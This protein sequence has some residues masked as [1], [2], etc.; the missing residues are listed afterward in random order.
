MKFTM[1]VEEAA[2]VLSKSDRTIRNYIKNGQLSSI[3]KGRTRLLDPEEVHELHTEG[4]LPRISMSEIRTMRAQIRRLEAEMAVVQHVLDLKNES[5]GVTEEYA[6]GLMDAATEQ[7]GR[8]AGSYTIREYESWANIFARMDEN[9]IQRLCVA[10]QNPDAWKLFLRLSARMV[11]EVTLSADYASS[12]ALQ[13]VHRLLAD[14]KRRFRIS[15]FVYAEMSRGLPP[16]IRENP[17]VKED[18]FERLKSQ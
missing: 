7:F 9:D 5:L 14:A 2:R 4:A 12:L 13:Q 16:E 8:P 15:C 1:T 3:R 11:S 10:V 17:T 6:K 18:L